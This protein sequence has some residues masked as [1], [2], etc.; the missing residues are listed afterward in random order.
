MKYFGKLIP[1]FLITLLLLGGQVQALETEKMCD[2][3]V[4]VESLSKDKEMMM[5][6]CIELGNVEKSDTNFG[7]AIAGA[8]VITAFISGPVGLLMLALFASVFG[9]K[10]ALFITILPVILMF[11][12]VFFIMYGFLK[13]LR[14]FGRTPVTNV[15]ISVTCAV[16]LLFPIPITGTLFNNLPGLGTIAG[17]QI[18]GFEIITVYA[19]LLLYFKLLGIIGMTGFFLLF[20]AGVYYYYLK[21]K[22]QWQTTAGVYSAFRDE[23][24][25][26][27]SELAAISQSVADAAHA[28]ATETDPNKRISLEAN[29]SKLIEKRKDLQERLTELR[30]STRNM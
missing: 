19:L 20:G 27:R 30:D 28:L 14:L 5:D 23:T 15:W 18:G 21:R 1:V 26:L 7:W 17:F 25:H 22:R 3:L 6:V 9:F 12:T 16:L 11:G 8:F 29:L 4:K 24:K 2:N 13:E 10:A